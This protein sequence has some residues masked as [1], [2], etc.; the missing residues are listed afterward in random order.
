MQSKKSIDHKQ[1]IVDYER[2]IQ[3]YEVLIN[4]F[5]PQ[6]NRLIESGTSIV[7]YLFAM[8]AGAILALLTFVGN[9]RIPCLFVQLHFTFKMLIGGV[10]AAIGSGF[11][12]YLRQDLS[13]GTFKQQFHRGKLEDQ[14][15]N[16]KLN[17]LLNTSRILALISLIAFVG[18]I[19]NALRVLTSACR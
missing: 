2:K 13:L 11:A 17:Y 6:Y 5:T 4:Q 9:E 16:Q 7:K 3:H 14:K 10:I 15:T 18:A 12:E 1:T 8:N 19:T